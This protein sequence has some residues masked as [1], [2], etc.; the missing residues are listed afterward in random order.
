MPIQSRKILRDCIYVP[1]CFSAPEKGRAVLEIFGHELGKFA[2]IRA[3]SH[4]HGQPVLFGQFVE[5]VVEGG[6]ILDLLARD[7]RRAVDEQIFVVVV[8]CDHAFDKAAQRLFARD[9]VIGSIVIKIKWPFAVSILLFASSIMILV[10]PV[11]L[12][13]YIILII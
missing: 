3:A 2:F 11:P 8:G 5:H 9:L 4:V 6:H 1:L 12:G 10:L 7:A 13:P